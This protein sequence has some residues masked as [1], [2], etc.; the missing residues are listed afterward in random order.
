MK[1]E[2]EKLQPGDYAPALGRWA[3]NLKAL[4]KAME[5]PEHSLIASR[6]KTM[7]WPGSSMKRS[8][9][10]TRNTPLRMQ[11]LLGPT[12]WL[13][14][15]VCVNPWRAISDWLLRSRR[16]PLPWMNQ[17]P[18]PMPLSAPFMRMQGNSTRGLRGARVRPRSEFVW[19]H[20]QLGP[21][22]RLFRQVR[23]GDSV[24]SK[25]DASESFCTGRILQGLE[26]G[27]PHG[28]PV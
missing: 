12:W 26:R 24:T 1:T 23:G 2:H 19:D 21:S 11:V 22:F 16:G 28:R 7:S 14:G 25:G 5:A 27:L 18:Q 20:L 3:R 10:W 15:L 9:P 8:S 6:K 4:L 13:G 17:S